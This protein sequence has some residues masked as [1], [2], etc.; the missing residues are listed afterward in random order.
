M[1]A[2]QKHGLFIKPLFTYLFFILFLPCGFTQTITIQGIAHQSY[3][4]K[5]IQVFSE[6]DQ[7][8]HLEQKEAI[9]T[10]ASDG[11]F[12]VQVV[13]NRIQRLKL[14]IE[15]ATFYLY[16]QP[17]FVYGITVPE[18]DPAL[19]YDNDAEL[20]LDI[21]I[22][23]HDTTE[24]NVLMMD[25]EKLYNGFF[26]GDEERFLSR[27]KMFKR[28]D[29]LQKV[30]DI[31]YLPL[32]NDYFKAH[33]KYS[34][35]SINASVSRGENYLING[36][37]LNKPI[38][39]TNKAYMDF[40]SSC[41]TGY[42]KAASTGKSSQSL[43]NLINSETNYQRLSVYFKDDKFL[44]NDTLRELVILHNLWS[45]SFEE[46]Y[47][48][49]AVKKLIS[50]I[51]AETRVEEHRRIAN[52]MLGFMNKL[53]VGSDAPLFSAR[54]GNGKMGS[55]Q[56]F[57]GKWVYLNFF[58]TGNVQSLREMPKIASLKKKFGDKVVF[59]SI[60]L[61][62]SVKSYLNYLRSNPRYDWPIW[63]SNEKGLSKTAKEAYFV[64]GTEAYFLISNFGALA[65]SPAPS[66]SEGIEY[67]FNLLFKPKRKNTKTG[68]R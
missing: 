45:F 54:A 40:F 52:N 19:K 30:C 24:L 20:I 55:L 26:A 56:Q 44:K 65:L 31:R 63:F 66:P 61:D 35:A 17:D 6:R 50:Q 38:L 67:R 49:N 4:G 28:A 1:K 53:L 27:Q 48:Q 7:I 60:C 25:F 15:Q 33:V 29:S 21:G 14:K 43:Q 23:G 13:S 64:S 34:I 47:D 37:I 62:D 57:K 8:T 36:Y 39:Y 18:I 22:L 46:D 58:S 16:V 41:F 32:R 3:A 51:A 2:L 5:I 42:L 68:I 11:Y 12:E 59:L 10:I 9:D